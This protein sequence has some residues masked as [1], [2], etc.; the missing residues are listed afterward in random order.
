MPSLKLWLLALWFVV[1]ISIYL[2]ERQEA[3]LMSGCDAVSTEYRDA[4]RFDQLNRQ[5][6]RERLDAERKLKF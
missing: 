5:R 1:V 3:S 4:C 6:E 2:I